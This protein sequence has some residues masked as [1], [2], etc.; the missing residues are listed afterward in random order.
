MKRHGSLIIA[1]LI[2]ALLLAA[3]WE[4]LHIVVLIPVAPMP[5]W[6]PWVAGVALF[7]LLE[8]A[9]SRLI[10]RGGK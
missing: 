10:N 6:L 3:I 2:F 8:Y 9:V 4:K 5:W 7:L 1:A